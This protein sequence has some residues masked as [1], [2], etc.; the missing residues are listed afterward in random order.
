ML[1]DNDLDELLN[2]KE[3][4]PAPSAGSHKRKS[5]GRGLGA[6]LGDD[7]I[8]IS[9]APAEVSDKH[10][11]LMVDIKDIKPSKYQPRTEFDKEA[12]QSL[13]E[14][15]RERVFF[16]RCLSANKEANMSLSPVNVVGVHQK[17]PG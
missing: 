5:L 4:A 7:S 6:L 15:I 14:S 11:A 13:A 10:D 8:S 16:S 3:A 12:L 2:D 1:I 17:L 9:D